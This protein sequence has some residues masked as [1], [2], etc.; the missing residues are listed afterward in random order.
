MVGGFEEGRHQMA[1]GIAFPLRKLASACDVSDDCLLRELLE[2]VIEDV[3]RLSC[4]TFIMDKHETWVWLCQT[5]PEVRTFCIYVT[6][7]EREDSYTELKLTRLPGLFIDPRLKR[8]EKKLGYDG[9]E[10]SQC[11]LWE[12]HQFVAQSSPMQKVFDL[13]PKID[14]ETW[15]CKN[16]GAE[17]DEDTDQEDESQ[18]VQEAAA[19]VQPSSE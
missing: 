19:Q 1:P 6:H 14:S 11:G 7:D 4:Y 18:E 16:P 12:H 10:K 3:S 5:K 9:D 2:Q 13:A 15:E 17:S 8:L